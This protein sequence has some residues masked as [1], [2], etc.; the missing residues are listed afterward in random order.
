MNS[1]SP[2]FSVPLTSVGR[3][4]VQGLD[5]PD[6]LTVD[7]T[8]GALSIPDGIHFDGGTGANTL[9]LNGAEV[10]RKSENSVGTET[11]FE[12]RDR[13]SKASQVVFRQNVG[14]FTDNLPEA[15]LLVKIGAALGD[16]FDSIGRF[17]GR[18]EQPDV[19][20]LG[21]S[22]PRALSGVPATAP[23]WVTLASP[24]A[25]ARPKSVI[26]TRSMPFS[27][28]MFAGLMSRWTNP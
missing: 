25:R 5:G 6:K 9:V 20:V 11:R 24:T 17:F 4:D 10:L 19:A 2:V 1:L 7:S 23:L 22:L 3:I 21:T 26:R 14:T 12:I 15:S 8:S 18:E 16:F 28:M 13:A 27:S